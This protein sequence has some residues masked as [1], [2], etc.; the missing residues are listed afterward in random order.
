MSFFELFKSKKPEKNN[1]LYEKMER[2][3][4]VNVAS[5]LNIENKALKDNLDEKIKENKQLKNLLYNIYKN[6]FKK[7]NLLNYQKIKVI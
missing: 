3:E 5:N 4:L 7:F 2:E 6:N 1:P